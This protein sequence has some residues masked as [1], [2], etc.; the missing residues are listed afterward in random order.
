VPNPQSAIRNPQ[1]AIGENH[2]PQSEQSE[3]HNP[4]FVG[5]PRRQNDL[6]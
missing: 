4:Q 6:E 2:N 5:G 3:I 1:S